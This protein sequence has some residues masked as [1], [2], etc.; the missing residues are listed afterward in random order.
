MA[1]ASYLSVAQTSSW[2]T[3]LTAAAAGTGRARLLYVG[4]SFVQGE[5][6]SARPNRWAD[7]LIG[8]LR[9]RHT[10]AGSG[11]GLTAHHYNTYLSVSAGWRHPGQPTNLTPPSWFVTQGN[12]GVQIGSGE[13]VEW[14]VTGDAV[15][16]VYVQGNTGSTFNVSVDG[17]FVTAIN[18][19]N[20]SYVPG[21]T[22][23]VSLG[24]AGSH[25]VR[26]TAAGNVAIDGIVTY[27]GDGAAGVSYWDCSIVGAAA[28]DFTTSTDYQM[29]WTQFLPHLVIDDLVGTNEF[30]N[31]TGATPTQVA[32]MLTARITVYKALASDPVIVVMVPWN[33][34]AISQSANGSGYTINQYWTASINAAVAAGV[35]VLDLRAVYPTASTEAWHDSD[36]LHPND[37]GHDKIKDAVDS[38]L[39]SK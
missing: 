24:S 19:N 2:G 14:T 31:N 1:A 21:R 15:D 38:F 12:R 13:H 17:A 28:S 33:A 22:A 8:E 18:T 20:A 34:P 4:D 3:A 29:A 36:G 16:V 30:L 32:N 6:A 7:S 27:N 37:T 25:T 5:G 11:V 23:R 39:V 35:A 9:A 26:C 10:I